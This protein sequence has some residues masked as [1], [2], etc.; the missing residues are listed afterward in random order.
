MP[1]FIFYDIIVNYHK[2]GDK[3]LDYSSKTN[4]VSNMEIIEIRPKGLEDL[5]KFKKE[6]TMSLCTP[7]ISHT[8][9]I[10]VEYMRN[11]FVRR[12][13]DG[14]FKS[15][16]IAGKNIL[17][18]YLNK[19]L[20]DYVKRGKPSLMITPRLDYEYNREFSSLYNFGKNI[21]SNKARFN[22]AFF[23]DDISGNLLS[24]Q[25]EQLRVEF[26]YKVK[27][28]SFN[29]AMDL[30][31]F[32]QLAFSPPTTKTKYI[33][34]DFVVPK[35]IIYAIVRDSGFDICDG[36]VLK[37]FEFISYL[38]KHSHLPFSYKFRGT[39]G[40]YEFYIRMTDMYTHLKF[41]NLELGEGERE[42][43]IDNNFI[44]SMDVECLFP[45]PQFYTYYSK[46]PTNLVNIPCE[47]VNR[48]R[49]IYHNMCFD[50]V[51]TRNEKGWGQYMSTDYVEDSKEFP[52]KDH[53][54]LINF[55][56]AIKRPD[57]NSFYNIAEAAKEQYI[58]PAVFMD[59]QLY[60][61]G[62][63]RDVTID[64]NTYSIIP[65]Q[66]LP[67]RISEIVFYVDLEYVNNFVLNNSKGYSSRVQDKD[68]LL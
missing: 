51:P 18:D 10:C 32:M 31:K 37:L 47:N 41:N 20:L 48:E 5:R 8:Y 36:D 4:D 54:Q 59:V 43:Q 35:E 40:E 12:F 14:Y 34:L 58:S 49:F 7:S 46:D 24:I 67:E 50:A 30:Y 17:A 39:K 1:F 16:F 66:P 27:V 25:M 33:D 22:D 21:Y 57:D 11:W 44:V 6:H 13:A 53:D 42:G 26:N 63:R 65:K 23:K 55:I 29:H 38:N 19:D 68:P 9:S 61:A 45:A 15:E 28:S 64:W 56:D 60:N 62:Q 52:I 3:N 2:K